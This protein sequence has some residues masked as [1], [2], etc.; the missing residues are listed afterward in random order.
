MSYEPTWSQPLVN[1]QQTGSFLEPATP[2]SAGPEAGTLV[3]LPCVNEDWLPL[4]LGA[5]DQLRN[6]SSWLG[7][8]TDAQRYDVLGQVDRLR[9]MVAMAINVPCCGVAMRLNA[10]CVL[11]FSVDGG[12]TWQD[13]S[14]WAA[15]FPGCVRSSIPVPV[16]PNPNPSLRDQH[17]CNIAGYLASIV[18]KEG[19]Q[20]AIT[21]TNTLKALE[22]YASDF[23]AVFANALPITFAV[24]QAALDAIQYWQTITISQMQAAIADATLWSNVTCAI[25]SAIRSVGYVDATNFA[26][27]HTNIAAV[28]Y[29]LS[30]LTTTLANFWTDLTLTNVQQLQNIGALDDVDCSN[31]GTWCH[32]WDFTVS[33]GGW[34]SYAGAPVYVA[35][36][37]WES[38]FD[39]PSNATILNIQRHLGLTTTIRFV[40]VWLSTPSP[41]IPGDFILE[42]FASG[43][44]VSDWSWT[45]TPDGVL[46]RYDGGPSAVT[47]DQLFFAFEASGS[48][49]HCTC[50][51]IQICGTGPNPFG[52]DNCACGV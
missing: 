50:T 17:A 37:G 27:A 47:G 42:V 30:G 3:Q 7:A 34:A 40:H 22:Q 11:Q 28:G 4:V 31:C 43:S 33:N 49:P 1:Y 13:V 48:T 51:R 45:A 26:Q 19:I 2:P 52:S 16:P 46:H 5:L 38:N 25:Y 8:L 9:Q 18:V 35:G 14:G 39:G 6:P 20:Q 23:S 29:S 15:N 44:F 41:N 36:V 10:A 32:E 24:S 21:S 12:A